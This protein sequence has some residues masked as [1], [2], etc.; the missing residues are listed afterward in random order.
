MSNVGKNGGSNM[1][2]TTSDFVKKDV[3]LQMSGIVLIIH[4]RAINTKI[5]RKAILE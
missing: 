2:W 4:K 1:S 3:K 5:S